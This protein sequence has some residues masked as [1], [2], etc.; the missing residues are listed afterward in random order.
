MLRL[1]G[2]S[3]LIRS[4]ASSAHFLQVPVG[5]AIRIANVPLIENHAFAV[6]PNPDEDKGYSTIVSNAGDWTKKFINPGA[7][8]PQKL[9][10]RELPTLDVMHIALL[11]K[12][13]VV[14]AIGSGISPCLSFVQTH[15]IIPV[16]VVWS[17]RS[18]EITYS[19]Q[20]IEAVLKADRDAIIIDTKATGR[21]D[22]PVI[23]Y[24]Q[25]KVSQVPMFFIQSLL[26]SFAAEE[27]RSCPYHQQS[28][29]H[30]RSRLCLGVTEDTDMWRYL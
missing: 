3:V 1:F 30:S 17:A 29:S 23:L 22:L 20:I 16:R 24:S 7:R 12:P 14:C 5:A 13:I 25:Y 11:S 21:P 27:C 28:E 6:I 19:P 9:W 15:P 2:R 4:V 18:P 10:M 8:R 26:T